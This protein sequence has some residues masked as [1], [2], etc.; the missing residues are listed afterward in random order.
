[1]KHTICSRSDNVIHLDN[2]IHLDNA[3]LDHKKNHSGPKPAIESKNIFGDTFVVIVN[4]S[5][6]LETT[7]SKVT[8]V[9][10]NTEKLA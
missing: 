8:M 1:M 2:M 7:R 10:L 6:V 9:V 3:F 5:A 4:F